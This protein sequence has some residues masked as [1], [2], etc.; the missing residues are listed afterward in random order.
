MHKYYRLCD[1]CEATM[2]KRLNA[3]NELNFLTSTSQVYIFNKVQIQFFI[4]F[5]NI[6]NVHKSNSFRRQSGNN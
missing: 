4:S 3:H 2:D 5:N 6:L 1:H